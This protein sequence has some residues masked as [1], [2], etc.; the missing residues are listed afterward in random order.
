MPNSDEG[1]VEALADMV[2][3]NNK[4]YDYLIKSTIV[5]KDNQII[6]DENIIDFLEK[7]ISKF[8]LEIGREKYCML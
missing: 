2:Q 1:K 5:S 4:L 8:E 6:I 7:N 3:K